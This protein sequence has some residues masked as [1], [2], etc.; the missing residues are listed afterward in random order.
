MVGWRSLTLTLKNVF[1]IFNWNLFPFLLRYFSCLNCLVVLSMTPKQLICDVLCRL[2]GYRFTILKCLRSKRA[3]F[4]KIVNFEYLPR[5]MCFFSVLRLIR[6][7]ITT[8]FLCGQFNITL[9]CAVQD[10]F[11]VSFQ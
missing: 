1:Q 11:S 2:G 6:F 3:L 4:S 7:S 8:V 5:E 10:Y 9:L